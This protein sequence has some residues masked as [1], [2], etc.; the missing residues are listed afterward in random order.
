LLANLSDCVASQHKNSNELLHCNH[1][2]NFRP[3]I[4]DENVRRLKLHQSV[5]IRHRQIDF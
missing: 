1:G 5:S 4:S 2:T 3:I